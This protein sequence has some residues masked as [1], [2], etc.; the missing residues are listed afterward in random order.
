VPVPVPSPGYNGVPPGVAG[1]DNKS[2]PPTLQIG[3]PKK[4]FIAPSPP[5]QPQPPPLPPPGNLQSGLAPL[6]PSCVLIGEHLQTLALNDLDGQ[7]WN[8]FKDRKGK[9]I[10]VDFWTANCTPC[11]KAMPVLTQLQNKFG[12]QGLEVVGISIDSGSVK[13]QTNRA[14]MLC[15]RLQTN[16]RQL[17]GQNDKTN[18]CGQFAV[19]AFPSLILLDDT[20]R[21]LWRHVGAPDQATLEHVLQKH[22]ANKAF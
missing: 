4:T 5:A 6:V 21:I 3:G 12:P 20:G 19:Q 14:K 13:D 16:Y 2:W 18:I 17:L 11:Q 1:I 8:F 10:L 15:Y 7:T 9:L 22:L